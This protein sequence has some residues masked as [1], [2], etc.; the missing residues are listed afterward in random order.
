METISKKI[1]VKQYPVANGGRVDFL[2]EYTDNGVKL[3]LDGAIDQKKNS[4]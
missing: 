3:I 2:L 4:T 1:G